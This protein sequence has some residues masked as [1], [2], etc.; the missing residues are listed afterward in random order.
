MNPELL[1]LD[2]KKLLRVVL[3]LPWNEYSK[4]IFDLKRARKF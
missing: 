4:D 2:S 1:I 3:D